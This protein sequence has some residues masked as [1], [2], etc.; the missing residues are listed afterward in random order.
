[1]I[2][3]NL[4]LAIALVGL[5]AVVLPIVL[6]F[7]I[8][9]DKPRKI[10]FAVLLG[11]FLIVLGFGVFGNVTIGG[12]FVTLDL[13]ARG[14]W[15]NASSFIYYN[16]GL[17]NVCLNLFMFI[18]VGIACYVLLNRSLWKTILVSLALSVLIEFG[19]FSLPVARTVELTDLVY[20]TLSGMI[21]FAFVWVFDLIKR[22][23]SK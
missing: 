10:V 21:G 3:I 19:Q 11:V 14:E 18:P 8:K 5:F 23:I 7:A 12:G 22:K 9:K 20:N 17:Q 16:F 1:M 15:F 13:V 4:Y 6:F 2:K